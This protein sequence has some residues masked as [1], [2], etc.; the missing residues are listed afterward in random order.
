MDWKK[1]ISD[2]AEIGMTQVQIAEACGVAQ[3]TV[4]DLARV[5][6][7]SCSF[8]LGSKLAALHKERVEAAKA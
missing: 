5:D 2:L 4:S 6:G 3:S 1:L 7:R 8:E